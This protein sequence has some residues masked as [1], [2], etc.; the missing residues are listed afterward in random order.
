VVAGSHHGSER[1]SFSHPR[2][3]L[4]LLHYIY[5]IRPQCDVNSLKIKFS[6]TGMPRYVLLNGER[7]FTIKPNDF[8]ITLS[9][10]GA[11]FLDKCLPK[12]YARVWVEEEFGKTVFAKHVI[13]AD[14]N[15]R[16]G[17]DVLIYKDRLIAFGKAVMS[18]EEMLN[19][20]FGEAVRVR[21]KVE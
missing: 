2:W 7:L 11:L 17:V 21:G 15:I 6:K 8:S 18:G 1:Q 10:K 16:R 4:D 5:G 9:K 19:L 14:P 12:P 13:D 3:L 20:N